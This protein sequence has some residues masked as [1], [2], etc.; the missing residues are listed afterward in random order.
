MTRLMGY[1][2][3]TLSWLIALS[4]S[5]PYNEH[6]PIKADVID[7]LTL[8]RKQVYKSLCD[9]KQRQSSAQ[10]M[11]FIFYSSSVKIIIFEM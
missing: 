1:S 2:Y 10:V 6:K 11:T 5:I 8:Q 7:E 4:C 3:H 9:D